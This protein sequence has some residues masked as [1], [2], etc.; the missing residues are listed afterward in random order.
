MKEKCHNN[1]HSWK[2]LTEKNDVHIK[3]Q[4]NCDISLHL[5]ETHVVY[6]VHNRGEVLTKPPTFTP[7]RFTLF[8]CYQDQKTFTTKETAK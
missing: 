7:Y 6:V 5:P 2:T 8:Q 4:T 1:D 3:K